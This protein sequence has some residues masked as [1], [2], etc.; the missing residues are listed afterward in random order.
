MRL[1]L[2]FEYGYDYEYDYNY[3]YD[4]HYDYEYDYEYD[5]E[6]EYDYDYDCHYDQEFPDATSTGF[7]GRPGKPKNPKIQASGTLCFQ[8]VKVA[9]SGPKFRA[10]V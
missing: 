6:Y 2:D 5:H 9:L 3:H 4:Y 1:L 7:L 8:F 10:R